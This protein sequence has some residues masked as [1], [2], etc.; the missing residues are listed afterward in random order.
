MTYRFRNSC[1]VVVGQGP[2]AWTTTVNFDREDYCSLRMKTNS[3]VIL[4]K[5]LGQS[6]FKE[7]Q[8]R[9]GASGGLG[10]Y[11]PTSEDETRFFR[12]FLAFIVL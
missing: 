7:A 11:S 8:G 6:L 9:G 1:S 2:P 3:L 12:R 4:M 10:G 5:T